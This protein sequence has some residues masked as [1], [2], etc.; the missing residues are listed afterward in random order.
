MH[1][2]Q[3][4]TVQWGTGTRDSTVS[5]PITFT[6]VLSVSA[7]AAYS[8]SDYAP[9]D[10]IGIQKISVTGFRSFS[11]NGGSG[12]LCKSIKYIVIGR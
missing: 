5:F 1:T 7:T 12:S 3:F 4:P 11:N 8:D 6:N 2:F 9:G 10:F